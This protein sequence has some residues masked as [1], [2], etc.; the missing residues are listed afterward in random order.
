MFGAAGRGLSWAAR[1][2]EGDITGPRALR[3]G[4]PLRVSLE[5]GVRLRFPSGYPAAKPEGGRAGPQRS[6]RA[7]Q[8]H[9]ASA[10]PSCG[11]TPGPRGPA[12]PRAWPG[13]GRPRGAASGSGGA[14]GS[15]AGGG[16]QRGAVVTAAEP[17]AGFAKGRSA[18][19]R[20]RRF[21]KKENKTWA[22]CLCALHRLLSPVTNRS[23]QGHKEGQ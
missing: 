7:G 16:R 20:S 10:P 19:T 11:C 17:S 22:V 21:F 23:H 5:G 3:A 18:F 12:P 9:A 13:R 6:G 14:G 4:F 15:G 2:G 1:C 8:V